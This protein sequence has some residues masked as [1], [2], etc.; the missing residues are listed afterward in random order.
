MSPHA[1]AKISLEIKQEFNADF[2]DNSR[3]ARELNEPRKRKSRKGR[4]NKGLR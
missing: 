1:K 3:N 4:Q 2:E